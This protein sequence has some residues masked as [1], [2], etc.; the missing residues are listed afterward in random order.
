[1]KQLRIL[2]IAALSF[3]IAGQSKAGRVYYDS[4]QSK[5]LNLT[6]RFAVYLPSGYDKNTDKKYPVFYL[7]HG[8]GDTET[9]WPQKGNMQIL[10]DELMR[11]G[12]ATEMIVIMPNCNWQDPKVHWGGY[13]DIDDWKYETFFFNEFIPFIENEKF[14]TFGDKGHRAVGG[15]SMGG[16]GSVSYCQRHPDKF[17]S[18]YDFSGWLHANVDSKSGYVT[19][20][21]NKHSCLEFMKNLTE[22]QKAQLRTVKWFIDCGDDDPGLENNEELYT[23]MKKAKVPC[24]M[25]IRDGVHNWEYWHTGLRLCLPFISR[26][27][28]K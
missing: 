6:V 16:G 25:R 13:F 28:S 4:I 15:L 26:N 20:G 2:L 17:S 12:E 8:Y 23:L 9:G 1:M 5:T 19:R 14:R 21:V 22:D 7:L 27:F 3:F 18:C 11:S 10:T 24:E